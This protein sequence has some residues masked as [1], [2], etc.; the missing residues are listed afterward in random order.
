MRS[1]TAACVVLV[2]SHFR[3]SA[4]HAGAEPQRSRTLP[5]ELA[6]VV[7][8]TAQLEA[9]PEEPRERQPR[10]CESH[11]RNAHQLDDASSAH[12]TLL[13]IVT[14]DHPGCST[15]SVRRWLGW[16][17]TSS[18]V[19]RHGRPKASTCFILRRREEAHHAK[20]KSYS[21]KCCK[22]RLFRSGLS[23]ELSLNPERDA[24]G[25]KRRCGGET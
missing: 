3:G 18:R 1:R 15:R 13:E 24:V 12:S 16:D 23:P 10:R 21:A 19:D 25:G 8:G 2:L 4:P 7:N 17:A 9:A 11:S 22:E 6:D 20:T 5:Q 14:Q